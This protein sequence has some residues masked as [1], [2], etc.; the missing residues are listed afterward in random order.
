MN[1]D[2]RDVVAYQ[3]APGAFSEAAALAMCGADARLQPCRTLEAVFGAVAGG[4]AATGVV[5][6]ENSLAGAVPGCADL[7]ERC[8]VRIVA[9]RTDR[10]EHA[11]VA[12]AGVALRDVRRV[13]SHPVAIAQCEA[14]FVAHPHL[15]PVPAFDT[16]GAV[17]EVMRHGAADAAAIASARAADLYGGVVLA[18][19]IQDSADNA[20]RF[21]RIEAGFFDG[22]FSAGRKTAL[23][24]R[25]RNAPGALARALDPFARRGLNLTRIESRPLRECPFEYQFHL[26]IAA[27]VDPDSLQ[28]AIDDLNA[29]ATSVRLLGHYPETAVA[30]GASA[31]FPQ[32]AADPDDR[33]ADEQPRARREGY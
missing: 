32:A 26:D 30:V 28:A 4:A 23:V 12:P 13:F 22:V 25:L 18:A 17:A 2:S 33:D 14:F 9:E 10:I 21:L 1:D 24:C 31:P 3:G 5:P 6:I 20:T 19:G 7:L 27:S 11:L 15:A 29:Q 8:S 16:A